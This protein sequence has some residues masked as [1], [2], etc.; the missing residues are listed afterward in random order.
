MAKQHVQPCID[1]QHAFFQE[2][3]IYITPFALEKIV[4][5]KRLLVRRFLE[6]GRQQVGAVPVP[7]TDGGIRELCINMTIYG[8]L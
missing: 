5:Q 2:V 7:Q 1:H 4:D 6:E 3:I 8:Q